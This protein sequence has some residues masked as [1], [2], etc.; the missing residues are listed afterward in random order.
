[1]PDFLL[2]N[3]VWWHRDVF[4]HRGIAYP[5]TAFT[6]SLIL[7]ITSLFLCLLNALLNPNEQTLIM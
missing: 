2:L 3:A 7:I 1:M 5:H 6:Y 4:C